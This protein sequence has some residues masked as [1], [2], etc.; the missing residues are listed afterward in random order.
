MSQKEVPVDG[1]PE[2]IGPQPREAL[3]IVNLIE[4][5]LSPQQ[6]G[7]DP[8]PPPAAGGEATRTQ[9]EATFPLFNPDAVPRASLAERFRQD[10]VGKEESK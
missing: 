3:G 8:T 6:P 4:S 2:D 1:I 10:L 5:Q 7:F 9:Q